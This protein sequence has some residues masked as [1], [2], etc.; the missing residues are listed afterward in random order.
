MRSFICRNKLEKS[1]KFREFITG[2]KVTVIKSL[3]SEERWVYVLLMILVPFG[4]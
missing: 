4:Y 2:V 3:T 1:L